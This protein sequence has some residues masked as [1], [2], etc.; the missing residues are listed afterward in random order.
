MLIF[1][2]TCRQV[3]TFRNVPFDTIFRVFKNIRIQRIDNFWLLTRARQEAFTHAGI[4][5]DIALWLINQAKTCRCFAIIAREF[6]VV[7]DILDGD[8]DIIHPRAQQHLQIFVDRNLVLDNSDVTVISV[9][10]AI[11][12]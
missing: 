11:K 6:R 10:S 12:I 7:L 5:R 4:K 1:E 8:F 9:G 3:K 2:E